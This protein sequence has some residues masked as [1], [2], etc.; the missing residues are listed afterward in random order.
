MSVE[1]WLDV[2]SRLP[3]VFLGFLIGRYLFPKKER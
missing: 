2:L 1:F 3:A